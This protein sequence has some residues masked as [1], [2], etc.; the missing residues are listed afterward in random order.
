[1]GPTFK[2]PGTAVQS[3]GQTFKNKPPFRDNGPTAI[4]GGE[5]IKI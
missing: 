3:K 5:V 1:M 4:S 2:L